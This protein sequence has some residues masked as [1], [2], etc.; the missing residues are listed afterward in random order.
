MIK[1][2]TIASTNN[3]GAR[4]FTLENLHQLADSCDGTPVILG[5][6]QEKPIGEVMSAEVVDGKLVVE[7]YIGDQYVWV[8]KNMFAVPGYTMPDHLLQAVGITF[9]PEDDSLPRIT[10]E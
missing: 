1:E 9:D 10:N 4:S 3:T 7:A 5:F 2:L 6:D 8:L